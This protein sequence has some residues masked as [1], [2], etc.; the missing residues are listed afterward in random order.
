M[1]FPSTQRL[2]SSYSAVR[3]LAFSRA[4]RASTALRAASERSFGVLLDAV[5]LPPRRPK[6]T[7]NGS[8]LPGLRTILQMIRTA[9]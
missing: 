8:L 2:P 1:F 9:A 5:A 6:A 3:F 4:Q 7:A